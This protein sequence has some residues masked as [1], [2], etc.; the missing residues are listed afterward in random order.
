MTQDKYAPDLDRAEDALIT[1][2]G[3]GDGASPD[4]RP[5][6]AVGPERAGRARA[7]GIRA[8]GGALEASAPPPLSY[9]LVV[10]SVKVSV[11]EY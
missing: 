6:R 3:A 10:D 11:L 8:H 1:A 7:G 2:T 4:L 5:R 9:G